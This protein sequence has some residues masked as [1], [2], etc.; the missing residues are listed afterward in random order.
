MT[1]FDP[2]HIQS[3]DKKAMG[4]KVAEFPEHLLKGWEIGGQEPIGPKIDSIKNIIFGGMGGSAIAGDMIAGLFNIQIPYIVNRNYRLPEFA[5]KDT[6][7]IASSYSGNTEETLSALNEA[8]KR[9]CS[10]LCVT[11][12]GK[13]KE[14]A[15]HS[16]YPVFILPG[17]YPPRAALGYSLGAFLHIFVRMGLKGVS[18]AQFIEAVEHIRTAGEKWQDTGNEKNSAVR[19]ARIMKGK[20]PLI[21]TSADR[22]YSVG[23]RW[24]TQINENSKSHA[25]YL[26]FPEMN[27]NEIMGWHTHASTN[28]FL[29]NCAMVILRDPDDH[30]R[31]QKRM[32]ITKSLLEDG[33]S[34]VQDITAE[35]KSFLSRFLYL[36]HLGDFVSYYLAVLYGVDPT[37]IREIDL[38]KE[39]L[40]KI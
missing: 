32:D 10:V 1:D 19:I 36:V 11:S 37:E 30:P 16:N 14:T 3:V 23:L 2:Q 5:G 28:T 29:P 39:G 27:H 8:E 31:I 38:L 20:F 6:L 17:G 34:T 25:A 9:G 18:E 33:G 13:V 12:G 21:N 7:F 15:E 22:L 4:Q 35:G 24:K 26:P 40:S